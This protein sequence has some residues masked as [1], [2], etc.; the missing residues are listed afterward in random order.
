MKILILTPQL[1]YPP[2][3]GTSLRN[4]HII[5]GLAE[6]H[7]L[8]LLSFLEDGQTADP[9]TIT[10]LHQLCQKIETISVPKR[11]TATRL[12]QLVSSCLP[13]MAH[14]LFSP[15]FELALRR[16]LLE[17]RFDVVQVEGIELAR[18]IGLIRDVQPSAK[19][20]FDDHN[21]ET[22]LQRRN[23][24]TD[25]QNPRRWLAAAYSW[26]QVGR[27]RRFERWAIEQADATVAVSEIDRQHLQKLNRKQ[28]SVISNRSLITVSPNCLDVASEND[29]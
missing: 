1:P 14:R 4:Y 26:V 24:L 19:I 27:L 12:R 6:G 10:P 21:A 13:D 8:T 5:R 15:V 9:Q 28:Y 7:Q 17:N 16:L 2:Q 20:V 29:K 3:Q 22:E 11:N 18:Y 25:V 23:F